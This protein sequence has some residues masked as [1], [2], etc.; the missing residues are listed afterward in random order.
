MKQIQIHEND[1]NQ[2]LDKFLTKTFPKLTRSMMYKAIRNKKIKVNRKR[3]TYDQILEEN[4]SILLFLPEDALEQKKHDIHFISTELDIVYEDHNIL[5]VNKPAGLLSQSDT[6]ESQDTLVLRIQGYLYNKK[7]YDPTR[8]QSFAPAICNRLDRNTT[9]LI[10]AAKNAHALRIINEAIAQRR[11]HKYYRCKVSG[12]VLKKNQI[13]KKYIRK[14]KTK[15]LVSDIVKEGF[16]EACMDVRV[17]GYEK[18]ST[19]VEIELHTG[20]F[21]QIRAL[22]AHIHHPLQGDIKYGYIGKVKSYSLCAYKLIFEDIGLNL[23]RSVFE[24]DL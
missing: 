2:R 7:E 23:E 19:F 6:S 20:R 16:K 14:E 13:I 4:D 18:E 24:I 15:A 17:L 10:I 9:G 11:I 12:K 8:E 1:A 21:H 3:C 22:M 5:I